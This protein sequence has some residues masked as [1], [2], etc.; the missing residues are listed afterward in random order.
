MMCY[1]LIR[2]LASL[3]VLVAL[4]HTSS[5][6]DAPRHKIGWLKVQS[7]THA[8]EE[9]KSF[10]DGL[11]A[12][13]HIQGTTFDIEERYA[14][15]DSSQLQRLVAELVSLGVKVIVAT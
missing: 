2:F 5:A 6:Q 13:G 10:V 11:R 4:A 3:F 12:H 9:L 15:G 14:D 1:S 7:R 8:P